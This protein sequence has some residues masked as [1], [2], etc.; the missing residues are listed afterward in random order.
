MPR[1]DTLLKFG[2]LQRVTAEIVTDPAQLAAVE[3]MRKRL[4]KR[5]QRGQTKQHGSKNGRAR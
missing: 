1:K 2:P 4:K 5:R 3:R